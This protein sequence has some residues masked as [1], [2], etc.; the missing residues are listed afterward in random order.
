MGLYW[1][2]MWCHVTCGRF[3]EQF[4]LIN[5]LHSVGLGM[6]VL[7][8]TSRHT[9]QNRFTSLP[10]VANGDYISR[11]V[12]FHFKFT[13]LN[14]T[15]TCTVTVYVGLCLPSQKTNHDIYHR[16]KSS[17]TVT[18]EPVVRRFGVALRLLLF[19]FLHNLLRCVRW[20]LWWF[21]CRA[22]KI[23]LCRCGYQMSQSNIFSG[24]RFFALSSVW[25][26]DMREMDNYTTWILNAAERWEMHKRRKRWKMWKIRK[27]YVAHDVPD[28][29]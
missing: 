4:S 21:C 22:N 9:A 29:Q 27:I 3:S 8:V 14:V 5:Y 20:W 1:H 17:A 28:T 19:F 6:A 26:F 13:E 18:L 2:K 12:A 7:I 16:N 10:C 11:A 24:E 15:S 25:K 23:N